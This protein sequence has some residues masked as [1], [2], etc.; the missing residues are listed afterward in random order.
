MIRRR[1]GSTV[2]DTGWETV[3]LTLSARHGV[4]RLAVAEGVFL[5]H[6]QFR[7]RRRRSWVGYGLMTLSPFWSH[8]L[9]HLC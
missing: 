8:F 9:V 7:S 3:P 5:L 1:V 4:F 6:I 2:G